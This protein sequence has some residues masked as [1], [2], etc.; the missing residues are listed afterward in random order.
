M[1]GTIGLLS[2]L[3]IFGDLNYIEEYEPL[4]SAWNEQ[5]VTK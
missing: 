2:V 1:H 5:A 3:H 4:S